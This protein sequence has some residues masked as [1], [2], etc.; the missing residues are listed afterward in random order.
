MNRYKRRPAHSKYQQFESNY[1][2]IVIK[3]I[4][5]IERDTNICNDNNYLWITRRW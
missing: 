2:P 4:P 1:P 5:F 3:D